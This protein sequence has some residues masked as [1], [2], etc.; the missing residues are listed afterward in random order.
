MVTP[1]PVE[2]LRGKHTDLSFLFGPLPGVRL[3]NV[4][5]YEFE[6]PERWSCLTYADS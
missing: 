4:V 2:V 1:E 3:D 6:L 5:A